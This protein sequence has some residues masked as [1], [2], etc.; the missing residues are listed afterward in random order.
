MKRYIILRSKQY[1]PKYAVGGLLRGLVPNNGS[2]MQQVNTFGMLG[3]PAASNIAPDQT[4][5]LDKQDVQN[6]VETELPNPTNIT[7]KADKSLKAQSGLATSDA[8]MQ[9]LYSNQPMQPMQ[10]IQPMQNMQ[11]FNPLVQQPINTTPQLKFNMGQQMQPMQG[12]GMQSAV[13]TIGKLTT[14]ASSLVPKKLPA[15][16]GGGGGGLSGAKV[17][18]IAGLAT[19]AM[20]IGTDIAGKIIENKKDTYT[21]GF[22][23]ETVDKKYEKAASRLGGFAKG[24]GSGAALGASLGTVIPGLG[25]AVGGAIGAVAG[26]LVGLFTSRARKKAQKKIDEY[27]EKYAK[28]HA[29]AVRNADVAAAQALAASSQPTGTMLYR[30]GGKLLE[31]PGA[32]NIITKG[33]LHKENNNLGNKDKGIP[34]VST[35]GKKEYE[36]EKEELILRRDATLTIE[37][38]V[39]KYDA[40]KDDAILE[41]IGQYVAS[42][43][44]TNTQDNS[45]KYKVKVKN[46]S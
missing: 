44:L 35:D 17:N 37:D 24:M 40:S 22:G 32:V 28:A 12:L 23:L 42:E 15:V 38:L 20:G 25:N 39:K 5:A 7:E 26:G 41:S 14:S 45:N 34:V 6:T 2:L 3:Q 11:P 21:D 9:Q 13:D 4:T 8:S 10:G 16:P 19:T 43:L 18:G 30:N 33:K 36:V 27:N 46:E 31:K 29:G 1:T